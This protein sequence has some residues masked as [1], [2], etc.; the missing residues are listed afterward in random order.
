LDSI[1]TNCVIDPKSLRRALGNFVTGVT[2]VTTRDATGELAGLTVNSFTSLSLSPPL[3]MWSISL[4]AAS[5][6]AFESCSHFIVN[7][8]AEDQIDLAE[9]FAR[10]G[11]DKFSG[12]AWHEGDVA[13]PSLD[14]V[15]AS[16][17]CRATLRYPGG[18]HVI[19]IGEVLSYHQTD[20]A[21][22]LYARGRYCQLKDEKP[23]PS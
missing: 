8:L 1:V 7:V 17:S 5:F 4:S 14:N 21:P 20:R 22:L 12:V 2:V 16:F 11:G 19:L 13:I 15:A 23:A 18:D 9:R 10:S 3:V 6:T